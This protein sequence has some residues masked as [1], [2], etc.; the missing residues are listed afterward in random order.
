LK[1]KNI[2]KSNFDTALKIEK[3][4]LKE[5]GDQAKQKYDEDQHR[6]LGDEMVEFRRQ[7]HQ[8]YHTTESDLVKRVIFYH[9]SIY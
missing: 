4:K 6:V 9:G 1:T 7:L 2:S 5:L 3:A 8:H